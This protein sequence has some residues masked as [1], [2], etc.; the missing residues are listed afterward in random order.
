[1]TN[2]LDIVSRERISEEILK[3]LEQALDPVKY[4][5]LAYRSGILGAVIEEF[6]P[7]AD[8][9]SYATILHDSRGTHHNESLYEHT[10]EALGRLQATG[11]GKQIAKQRLTVILHDIG[12]IYTQAVTPD[13]KI[14]YVD[15]E[16]V[17]A[18]LVRKYLHNLK[19]SNDVVNYVSKLVANHMY[20][21]NL[22]HHSNRTRRKGLARLYIN[23]HEDAAFMQDL[24]TICEADTGEDF[25]DFRQLIDGFEMQPRIIKGADVEIYEP[26][27]R[28]K[29]IDQMRFIQFTQNLN[30]AKLHQLVYGEAKN[31]LEHLH[32]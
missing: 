8:H 26:R 19:F 17:G 21:N 18:D 16:K 5:Q 15:H 25:T 24:I 28:G 31:I 27:I 23:L 32:D 13:G 20:V 3:G 2:R 22:R 1:M 9:A 29:L 7:S 4:F 11:T 14:R 6:R 30:M 12:K 10:A